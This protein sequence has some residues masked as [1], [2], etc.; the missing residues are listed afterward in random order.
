MTGKILIV[1]STKSG[2]NEAAA[3]AMADVFKTVYG[4]DVTVADLRNGQPDIAPFRNIIVGGG[5]NNT[6][7]YN[8]AVDF[9]EKD[10]WGKNVA[11]YFSCEDEEHQSG[12][13]L[14]ITQRRC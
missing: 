5:V 1:Y 2:I 7:V 3:H 11:V 4:M 12:K 13:V 10:F 14:K 9:L 6:S 8:E